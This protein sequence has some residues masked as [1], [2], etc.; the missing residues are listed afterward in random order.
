LELDNFE[1][2]RA[3]FIQEVNLRKILKTYLGR[4][5]EYQNVYWKK[6]CTIRWT[7]FGDEN[8]KKFQSIATERHI[9]NSIA[10]ILL[11]D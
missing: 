6:H 11:N 4:L 5:L 10:T 8:T 1:N 2:T 9:R 3:L 7:K